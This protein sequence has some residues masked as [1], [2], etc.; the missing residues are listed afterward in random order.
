MH[1]ESSETAM[2][3]GPGAIFGRVI[4][5][6]ILIIAAIYFLIPL[7]VMIITSL[8]TMNDIRTGHLISWPREV[9]L[10]ARK[11]AWGTARIGIKCDG[12]K[13]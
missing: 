9:T 4:I 6:T 11:E 12:I 7:F 2:Y 3:Q 13:G 8:K 10:E 5:Y 1:N